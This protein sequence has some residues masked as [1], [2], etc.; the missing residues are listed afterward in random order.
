M[1]LYELFLYDKVDNL[2]KELPVAITNF[3]AGDGSRPNID[4]PTRFFRR[5]YILNNISGK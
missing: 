5:F 1:K 3:Q 2:Y 4:S